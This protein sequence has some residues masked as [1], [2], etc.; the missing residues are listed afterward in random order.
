MNHELTKDEIADEEVVRAKVKDLLKLGEM[1]WRYRVVEEGQNPR[2]EAIKVLDLAQRYITEHVYMTLEKDGRAAGAAQDAIAKHEEE[3]WA[4]ELSECCQGLALARLIFNGNNRE[5]DGEIDRYLQQ[6]HKLRVA[7][8]GAG[9]P[10]LADTQNSLGALAQKQKKFSNAEGWY[11]K[12][13]RTREDINAATVKEVQQQQQ[14]L[15]Q[16]Y[17]SLGN[18]YSDMAEYD[19][20]L[21]NLTHAKDCYIKGFNAAH[22]KVAWAVEAQAAV[23]K[24]MK[25]HRLAQECIQEAIAIRT[26]LQDKGDGKA[27]FAKELEKDQGTLDE[28]AK[29]RAKLQSKFK[30]SGKLS[31]S[32]SG[33][34]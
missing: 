10:L 3:N 12:S 5:E 13:L 11:L 1:K 28:V 31:I 17:T 30:S 21:V 29:S 26:A 23:H 20:A 2:D 9:Q 27:L 7:L 25:N 16:S 22:P 14:F 34:Q 32:S 18:L 33:S 24:K 8:K 15:A 6:A 4:E 19:K